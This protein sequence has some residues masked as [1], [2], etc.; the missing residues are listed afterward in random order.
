VRR[1][2][3]GWS[4]W[5]RSLAELIRP[6]ASREAL[7]YRA[8]QRIAT[9]TG[10]FGPRAEPTMLWPFNQFKKPRLPPRGTIETIYG[11]M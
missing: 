6:L 5:L 2:H 3:V 1:T 9:E 11:M 4:G 8:R 7:T 10:A